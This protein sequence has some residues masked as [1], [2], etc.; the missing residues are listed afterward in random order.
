MVV[1]LDELIMYGVS[2]WSVWKPT[3]ITLQ[4]NRMESGLVNEMA[5]Q[6]DRLCQSSRSQ[7]FPNN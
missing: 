4:K 5:D 7:M 1:E 3:P 6:Q 2:S